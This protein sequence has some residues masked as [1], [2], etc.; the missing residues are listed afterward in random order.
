MSPQSKRSKTSSIIYQQRWMDR[1]E[2]LKN[3]KKQMGTAMFH[4]NIL[5]GLVF[6]SAHK[7]QPI[8]IQRSWT[9]IG[10]ADWS[11]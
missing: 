2:E 8:T 5:G 4:K 6:G 9:M 7:E 11:Q 1:F 10:S 3:T